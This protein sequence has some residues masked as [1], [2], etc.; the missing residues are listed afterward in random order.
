MKN[1]IF[2]CFLFN[3]ELEILDIRMDLLSP[4]V[5]YFLLV[6][7]PY[8]FPGEK[9]EMLFDENKHRFDTSKIIHVVYED[10]PYIGNVNGIRERGKENE[11][12]SRDYMRVGLKNFGAN[13]E[14]IIMLSDIDEIPNMESIIPELYKLEDGNLKLLKNPKNKQLGTSMKLFYYYVNYMTETSW[15]G[16]TIC[17]FKRFKKPRRIRKL[18]GS[19]RIQNGGW[20]YSYLGGVD[21]IRTKIKRLGSV[22]MNRED[23]V[24][25]EHLKSCLKEKKDLYN[26][27]NKIFTVDAIKNGPRNLKKFIDKY[28]YIIRE[29]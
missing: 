26:R 9:K 16:T 13:P 7:S 15:G 25:P 19:N 27:R 3:T 18:K 14:D 28:P 4:Y 20:H 21:R 1:K 11:F 22:Q 6:E 5:D 12:A 17:K 2:D 29:D 23:F 8:S 24:D 10:L